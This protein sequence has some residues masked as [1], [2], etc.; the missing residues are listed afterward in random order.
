MKTLPSVKKTIATGGLILASLLSSYG[1]TDQTN[2]STTSNNMAK[3]ENITSPRFRPSASVNTYGMGAQYTQVGWGTLL[4]LRQ[5]GLRNGGETFAKFEIISGKGKPEALYNAEGQDPQSPA[6]ISKPLFATGIA[7]K[8]DNLGYP[9]RTNL[10]LWFGIDTQFEKL[11]TQNMPAELE[12]EVNAVSVSLRPYFG[13]EY[14][15]KN[16]SLGATIGPVTDSDL[17]G[18]NKYMRHFEANG[19]SVFK[20]LYTGVHFTADFSSLTDL[21]K[22]DNPRNGGRPMF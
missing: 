2:T 3:Q 8:T 13:L 14:E 10:H 22:K 9:K 4:S 6:I 12:K 17:A 5:Q 16:W 11:E 19:E 7:Y 15:A 18:S 21:V 1:H 20:G